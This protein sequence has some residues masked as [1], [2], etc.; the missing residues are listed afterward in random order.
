MEFFKKFLVVFLKGDP[1]F[2]HNIPYRSTLDFSTA[3][4]F[5]LGLFFLIKETFKKENRKKYILYLFL[6][7]YFGQLASN[8]DMIIANAPS[9][10]RM[11]TISPVVYTISSFGLY[12]VYEKSKKIIKRFCFYV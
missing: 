11:L 7:F 2:R 3:I 12:R 1:V 9:I 10:G 8:L 5:L 6:P 4:F